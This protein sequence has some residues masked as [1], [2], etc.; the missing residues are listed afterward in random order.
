MKGYE[1]KDM[2]KSLY[3][4]YQTT[5]STIQDHL[6]NKYISYWDAAKNYIKNRSLNYESYTIEEA[7]RFKR[8][9][10]LFLLATGHSLNNLTEDEID[11]IRKHDIFIINFTFLKKEFIPTYFLM[12]YEPN[13][14]LHT[15]FTKAFASRR[16]LYSNTLHFLPMKAVYRLGHPKLT[17]YFFAEKPKLCIIKIP[18]PVVIEERRPFTDDDFTDSIIY[19]GTGSLALHLS[20][21][22]GY[23][24]IIQL[25]VDLDSPR[26]FYDEKPELYEEARDI[27]ALSQWREKVLAEELNCKDGK[28]PQYISMFPKG[29][30]ANP[31]DEYLYF[32][33]DY[34]KRKFGITL[35]IGKKD[36]ML[37][38]GL[39]A[40]FD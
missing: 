29:N 21:K 2:L 3:S 10:T 14:K 40:Y 11:T 36:N 26:H 37:Y 4:L 28:M 30:K 12:S 15:A 24:K 9:D 39:P 19:R 1:F 34:L 35:Y 27:I 22:L 20:V 31:H 23:K 18:K 13:K 6:S 7:A 38:P 33:G 25:G 5:G 8:S 32:L 17:P 16:K